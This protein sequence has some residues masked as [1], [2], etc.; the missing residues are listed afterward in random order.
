MGGG[1][2]KQELSELETNLRGLINAHAKQIKALQDDLDGTKRS[3]NS[4]L[5]ECA[6]A[7]EL[8]NLNNKLETYIKS[9]DAKFVQS[10]EDLNKKVNDELKS[11]E[12]QIKQLNNQHQG[13]INKLS[14]RV[15]IVKQKTYPNVPFTLLLLGL[16]KDVKQAIWNHI[17]NFENHFCPATIESEPSKCFLCIYN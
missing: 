15:T 5:S 14:K 12:Q 2:S 9:N 13:D 4:K 3:L 11:L 6:S 8:Q 7:L 1:V 16:D 17:A 10:V